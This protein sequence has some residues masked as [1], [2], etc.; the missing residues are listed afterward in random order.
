LTR[1]DGALATVFV[2]DRVGFAVFA[3]PRGLLSSA[4]G[5]SSLGSSK[6]L[7]K[8]DVAGEQVATEDTALRTASAWA[9][10]VVSMKKVM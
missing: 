10:G 6:L 8:A 1:F 9:R 7:S 5:V 3:A 2:L 4:A